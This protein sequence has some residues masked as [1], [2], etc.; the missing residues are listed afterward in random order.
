MKSMHPVCY[1]CYLFS[2]LFALNFFSSSSLST[3]HCI[4]NPFNHYSRSWHFLWT[5]RNVSFCLRNGQLLI[6]I[7]YLRCWNPPFQYKN[8]EFSLKLIRRDEW[9]S[10]IQIRQEEHTTMS[11]FNGSY[12]FFYSISFISHFKCFLLPTKEQFGVHKVFVFSFL[13]IFI[14]LCNV[15]GTQNK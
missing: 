11:H 3:T 12:T 13:H 5:S 9:Q 2:F 8:Q 1:K 14:C 7:E 10:P 15:Q 4:K 6:I